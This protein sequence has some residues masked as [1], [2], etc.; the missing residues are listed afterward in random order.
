MKSSD[1]S[2]L[3]QIGQPNYIN[4]KCWVAKA[5]K[6]APY[7][8]CKYCT[9]KK[10]T[11][12]PN[13]KFL[14]ISIILILIS[15]GGAF[16]IEKRLLSNFFK[17]ILFSDLVFIVFYGYLFNKIT[18]ENITKD[19]DAKQILEVKIQA[20]TKELEE[21]S[22]GLDLK[23]KEKTKELQQKIEDLEKFR[24]VTVGREIKM[25]N[26]KE[27][28]KQLEKQLK[29]NTHKEADKKRSPLKFLP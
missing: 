18:I 20:K 14:I 17:I 29:N 12:C 28:V 11:D 7:E 15:L 1:E 4:P 2:K 23:V 13:F 9:L 19:Y 25:I 21:L 3:A 10:Y 5:I 6:G 27:K 24:H 16:L 22:K 26:L 8:R